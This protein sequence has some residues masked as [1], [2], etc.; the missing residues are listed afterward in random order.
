[1]FF[2]SLLKKCMSEKREKKFA[3]VAYNMNKEKIAAIEMKAN[4]II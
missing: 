2:L 1:M 3:Y 4:M